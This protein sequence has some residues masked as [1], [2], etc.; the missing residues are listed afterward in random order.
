[1]A[2]RADRSAADLDD[3]CKEIAPTTELRRW[4]GHDPSRWLEFGQRYRAEIAEPSH[5][6]ALEH[7]RSIVRRSDLTLLT[8]THDIAHSHAIVLAQYLA[9]DVVAVVDR[10]RL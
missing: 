3:W 6:S 10:N 2:A 5:A 8:A 9:G 7:L 1:M 4:F